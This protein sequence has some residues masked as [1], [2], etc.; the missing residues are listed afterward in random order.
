MVSLGAWVTVRWEQLVEGVQ[1]AVMRSPIVQD[2][3]PYR[4]VDIFPTAGL[5]L[6]DNRKALAH[7]G[8][9]VGIKGVVNLTPA[10]APTILAGVPPVSPLSHNLTGRLI[11]SD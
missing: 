10:A 9:V 5:L 1:V 8:D 2:D 7:Q 4:V 6:P 11:E 3:Y